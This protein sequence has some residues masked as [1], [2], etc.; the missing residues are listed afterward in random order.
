MGKKRPRKTAEE[1]AADLLAR[2]RQRFEA[3]NLPPEVAELITGADIEVTRSGE[4]RGDQT[5]KEDSARRLDAFAALK[6]GMDK[7]CFDAARRLERDLLV[8]RGE[9]DRGQR[10]ERVDC[11]AGLD[12][13]D[14]IVAA[15]QSCDYIKSRLSPR[16]WWLLHELIQPSLERPDWRAHV[17]YVTGE[18]N[19][20]AQGALVRAVCLNLRDAY[21]ELDVAPR[22]AA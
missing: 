13:T 11:D 4:K 10:V 9:G 12:L 20:N 2:K 5:V 1:V 22:R 8:R 16:D 21:E 15:G 3:V 17:A 7:G 14:L 6:D 19:W 18:A